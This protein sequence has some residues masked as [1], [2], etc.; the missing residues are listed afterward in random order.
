MESSD[1]TNSG[2]MA[3]PVTPG[4]IQH[5]VMYSPVPI[6]PPL[7]VEC[8]DTMDALNKMSTC[9]NEHFQ[10]FENQIKISLYHLSKNEGREAIEYLEKLK[11]KNK[12][13]QQQVEFHF[14]RLKKSASAL[15]RKVGSL[16][17]I[18]AHLRQKME[19]F[20]S[21]FGDEMEVAEAE[22]E[23]TCKELMNQKRE[24][25]NLD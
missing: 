11:K 5:V 21:I 17:N 9:L 10:L 6:P 4:S 14:Q 3:A 1:P 22:E 8:S 25:D 24:E 18:E 13:G 20:S 23:S 12:C 15:T 16:Q 2:E 7:P 19:T